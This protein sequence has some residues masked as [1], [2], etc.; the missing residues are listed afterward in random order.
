MDGSVDEP[1]SDAPDIASLLADPSPER[2]IEGAL[3]CYDG[4]PPDLLVPLTHALAGEADPRVRA[5]LVKALA[6]L[7]DPSSLPLLKRFVRD[8]DPRV[9]SNTV[10]AL[11]SFRDASLIKVFNAALTDPHPRVR[12]SA[13][14]ALAPFDPGRI[15]TSLQTLCLSNSPVSCLT[16][17]YAL[18]T[19]PEPWAVTLLTRM[20]AR[21]DNPIRAQNLQAIAMLARRR[22]PGALE[23]VAALKSGQVPPLEVEPGLSG[24]DE[25]PPDEGLATEVTEETLAELLDHPDPGTRIATIQE[26]GQRLDGASVIRCFY[27][28]LRAETDA[29]VLATLTKWI[30]RIGG[31]ESLQALEPY[32][33]HEDPRVRANTL[34]GLA[35]RADPEIRTHAETLLADPTPRVRAVAADIVARFDRA[36][37][38]KVLKDMLVSSTDEVAASALHALEGLAVHQ[39]LELL[40]LAMLRSGKKVAAKVDQVLERLEATVPL[41]ARLRETLRRGSLDDFEGDHVRDLIARMNSNDDAVRLD[42]LRRLRFSTSEQAWDVIELAI[43]DRSETVQALAASIVRGREAEKRKR[44]HLYDFGLRCLQLLEG[45]PP[46][47]PDLADLATRLGDLDSAIEAAGPDVPLEPLLLERRDTIIVLGDRALEHF[48]RGRFTDAVLEQLAGKVEAAARGEVE[49]SRPSRR[50][51]S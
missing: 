28:R 23:A 8:P 19:N 38:F 39:I 10:E 24:G 46:Q 25:P 13:I 3:R 18:S 40:E 50:P 49:R 36:R 48:R 45:R 43:Y 6:V 7:A 26:A 29:H 5:T 35:D 33:A 42:A 14:L 2:R 1:G 4:A 27:A 51:K 31:P 15:R 21:P 47:E 9:R 12:A 32:L 22:V 37:A 11:A 34:E 17:I 16:A 20:A 44:V 30:G 41:A